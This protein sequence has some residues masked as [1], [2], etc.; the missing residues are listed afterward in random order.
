MMKK[1]HSD[2][3]P[4][5]AYRNQRKNNVKQWNDGRHV[6]EKRYWTGN[7]QRQDIDRDKQ[8]RQSQP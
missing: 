4:D 1:S 7:S 8:E 3:D 5:R 6:A 2:V